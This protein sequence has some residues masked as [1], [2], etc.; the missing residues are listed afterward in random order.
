MWY[1]DL[2]EYMMMHGLANP[3]FPLVVILEFYISVIFS[4]LNI[5][6]NFLTKLK[7]TNIIYYDRYL[8]IRKFGLLKINIDRK[9]LSET[10]FLNF[11]DYDVLFSKC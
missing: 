10:S 4:F 5:R 7:I 8:T 6:W 9:F 1:V 11:N 2:F 3:K